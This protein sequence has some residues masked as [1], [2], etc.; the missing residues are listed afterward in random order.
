MQSFWLIEFKS[1]TIDQDLSK[2]WKQSLTAC[3]IPAPKWLSNADTLRTTV[4]FIA[5]IRL[6]EFLYHFFF[7][8]TLHYDYLDIIKKIVK[9]TKNVQI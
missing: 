9:Q 3:H 2:P 1:F 6:S 4:E 5:I 7:S 8:R